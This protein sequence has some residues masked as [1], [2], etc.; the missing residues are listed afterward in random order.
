MLCSLVLCKCK[1]S[2]DT[3]NICTSTN[4]NYLFLDEDAEDSLGEDDDILKTLNTFKLPDERRLEE[5]RQ[6]RLMVCYNVL[7][8]CGLRFFSRICKVVIFLQIFCKGENKFF[9]DDRMHKKT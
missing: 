7:F 2:H 4:F 8:V 5:S 1:N 3:S 6:Q 9:A